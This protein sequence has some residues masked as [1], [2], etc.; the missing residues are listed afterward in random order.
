MKRYSYKALAPS[1]EVMAGTIEAENEADL[2]KHIEARGMMAVDMKVENGFDATKDIDWRKWFAKSASE[3]D[4][5]EFL[6]QLAALLQASIRLDHALDLLSHKDL[7]GA[8]AEPVR[9]IRRAILSGEPL[10]V[11]LA[12]H[13][14]LFPDSM[15]AL[16][17]LSEQSG[18]LADAMVAIASERERTEKLKQKAVDALTYPAFLLC[19]VA[20]VLT[21]FVTLVLPQFRPIIADLGQKADPVLLALLDFSAFLEAHRVE[22]FSLLALIILG[23]LIIFRDKTRRRALAAWVLKAP[24]LRVIDRDYRTARFCR[25][26]GHLVER[27]ISLTDA[28]DL[29][30]KAIAT[31][32]NIARFAL[33]RDEIRQG[34]RVFDS[35]ERTGA[36]SPIALRLVRIGEE[37]GR[38]PMIALKAAELFET[39]VERQMEKLVGLIGP[40]AIIV[41]S[42]IVG[43][44]IVSVMTALMSIN[45]MVG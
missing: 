25:N 38:M 3:K 7:A 24:G 13:G 41:V 8:M 45:Q 4:V 18:T 27:G 23:L 15:R 31:P 17:A 35:L 22:T 2:R 33:A 40:I 16:I 43:G 29:T 12:R 5:T 20:A 26:F 36:L 9:D 11:A 6:Q 37:T 42:L 34:R 21:F 44:L 39:R 14:D 19:A 28:I 32:S 30:G 10:S 1:G